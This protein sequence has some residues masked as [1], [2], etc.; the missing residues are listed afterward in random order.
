MDK[1]S[2]EYV[3]KLETQI[4]GLNKRIKRIEDALAGELDE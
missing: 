4:E 3:D 2:Y 1:D